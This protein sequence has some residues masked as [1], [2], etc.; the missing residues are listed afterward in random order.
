MKCPS[1]KNEVHNDSKFCNHCGIKLELNQK[2]CTNKECVDFG[3]YVLPLDSKYCPTCGSKIG[4]DTEIVTVLKSFHNI[5][6]GETN[7]YDVDID[8]YDELENPLF[9]YIKTVNG[10]KT[11][12]SGCNIKCIANQSDGRIFALQ[13]MNF[14]KYTFPESW[15]SL[16]IKLDNIT[17]S[18]ERILCKNGFEWELGESSFLGIDRLWGVASKQVSTNIFLFIAVCDVFLMISTVTEN[19]KNSLYEF[20]REGE[21]CSEEDYDNEDNTDQELSSNDDFLHIHGIVIGQSNSYDLEAMGYEKISNKKGFMVNGCN[22]LIGYQKVI[23]SCVFDSEN[24]A[25]IPDH[26]PLR[27]YM[28]LDE[29][30][31]VLE[32]YGFI[33]SGFGNGYDSVVD[34]KCQYDKWDC[35]INFSIENR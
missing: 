24:N 19:V 26:I 2:A 29:V 11:D 16:G 12:K 15:L 5:T 10:I 25:E 23:E 18:M 14:E 33:T 20:Y 8:E 9:G 13:I 34:I 3:K 21:C 7:I 28:S 31:R 22:F 32:S 35:L 17:V 4:G 27:F 1:C 30:E 6:L